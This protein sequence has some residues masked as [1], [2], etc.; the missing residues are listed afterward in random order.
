MRNI[1]QKIWWIVAV[2]LAAGYIFVDLYRL[3]F[4]LIIFAIIF[5]LTLLDLD[6]KLRWYGGIGLLILSAF[7]FKMI[8]SPY[9][10]FINHHLAMSLSVAFTV[11]I[12][13][14]AV[15]VGE[16]I[17]YFLIQKKNS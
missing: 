2:Y 8:P 9:S 12:V 3:R 14:L 15:V 13:Y 1:K 10:Y 16:L 11:L 5:V 17:Y 4:L 7:F 6:T